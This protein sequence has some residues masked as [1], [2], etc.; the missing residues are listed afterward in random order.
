M[1]IKLENSFRPNTQAGDF[2]NFAIG[3]ET[4]V[5]CYSSMVNGRWYL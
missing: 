5:S 3:T 1:I 2:P 4:L